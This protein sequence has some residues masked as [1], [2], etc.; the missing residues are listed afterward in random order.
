MKINDVLKKY[1]ETAEIFMKYGFHCIGCV[2]AGFESIEDGAKVHG[3]DIDKLVEELN[4]AIKST[5]L[6]KNTNIQNL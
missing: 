6:Q 5:K 3:I 1:P 4:E 2:A